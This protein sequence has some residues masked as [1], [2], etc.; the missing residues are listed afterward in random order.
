MVQ[1]KP[2]SSFKRIL[3]SDLYSPLAAQSFAT[4]I[5]RL[6]TC[7]KRFQESPEELDRELRSIEDYAKSSME[8]IRQFLAGKEIQSI[9]PGMLIE[10]LRDDL[11]FTRDG[12]GLQVIL[13]TAP[14]DLNL[15]KTVEQ[16]LYRVL[17]EVLMNIARHSHTNSA[18][19]TLTQTGNFELPLVTES[20]TP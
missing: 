5:L 20:D 13:E 9:T 16:D 14:D 6:E 15:S 3:E 10:K 18:N 8:V 17:R 11:K 4:L 19:V 1:T 2:P 12:L 7:R